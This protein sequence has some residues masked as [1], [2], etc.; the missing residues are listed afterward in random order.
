MTTLHVLLDQEVIGVL[1][2]TV[3]DGRFAFTYA[4]AWL[5]AR[6][7]YPLS[8]HKPFCHSPPNAGAKQHHDSSF[9]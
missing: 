5:D 2:N 3:E 4:Q 6:Q 1:D 9:F 7:R 8:P